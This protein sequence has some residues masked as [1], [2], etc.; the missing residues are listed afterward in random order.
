MELSAEVRLR[1]MFDDY[2]PLIW[3]VLRR[4][5]A[6]EREADDLAQ[7][8]FIVAARRLE[9]IEQGR[10][11]AFLIGTAMRV[12]LQARRTRARGRQGLSGDDPDDEIAPGPDVAHLVERKRAL[13]LLDR[14]FAQMPADLREVLVLFEFGELPAH[15]IAQLVGIPIGTVKSRLRRAREELDV[16]VARELARTSSKAG[17]P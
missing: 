3:R 16:R 1:R 15:E 9:A 6:P 10:E 8:V 5:G 4:L 14:V 2:H 13:E 11:R 12:A 17:R 7:D